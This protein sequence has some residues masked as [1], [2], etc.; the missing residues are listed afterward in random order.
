MSLRAKRGNLIELNEVIIQIII[1]FYLMRLPRSLRSLA[2]TLL[3][4]ISL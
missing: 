3:S 4:S 2:M 1:S